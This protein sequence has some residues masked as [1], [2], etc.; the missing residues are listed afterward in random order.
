MIFSSSFF[1]RY[2]C[3]FDFTKGVRQNNDFGIRSQG[4]GGSIQ[5]SQ[6]AKQI[7]KKKT[8]VVDAGTSD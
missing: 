7:Y 5:G 4:A 8:V 6:K 2:V 1:L 3:F